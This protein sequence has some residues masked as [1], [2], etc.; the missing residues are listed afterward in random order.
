MQPQ[1]AQAI[2]AIIL[3]MWPLRWGRTVAQGRSPARRPATTTLS[4]EQREDGQSRPVGRVLFRR[5]VTSPTAANIPLG[6]ALPPVSSGRP[7]SAAGNRIA[8][9]CALAPGGACRAAHV[10]MGAVRSY[11]T[12]SPLPAG[13]GGLFSVALFREAPRLAVSQH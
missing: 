8:P 3:F 9:L 12:V 4:S 10:A 7:G 1:T 5:F 2:T 6:P 13:A 11:R